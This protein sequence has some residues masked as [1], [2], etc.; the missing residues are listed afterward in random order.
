VRYDIYIYIHILC[1]CVCVYVVR[2]QRVKYVEKI[3]IVSIL[4]NNCRYF[5]ARRMSCKDNIPL[6]SF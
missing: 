3:K 1:V 2:R 6:N 4:E 5:S